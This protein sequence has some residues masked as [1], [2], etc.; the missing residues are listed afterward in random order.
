MP[1]AQGGMISL[2]EQG[3]NYLLLMEYLSQSPAIRFIFSMR[4]KACPV[5]HV[6]CGNDGR[7]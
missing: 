1:A 4:Y 7:S 3:K 5:W 6:Y 2:C